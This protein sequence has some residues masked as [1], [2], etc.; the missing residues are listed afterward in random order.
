M[1][2]ITFILKRQPFEN[3]DLDQFRCILERSLYVGSTFI[4]KH[5]WSRKKKS[6]GR[7]SSEKK[8]NENFARG[9]SVDCRSHTWVRLHLGMDIL[10]SHNFRLLFLFQE[11][12]CNRKLKFEGSISRSNSYKGFSLTLRPLLSKIRM[13]ETQA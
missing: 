11:R 13:S 12:L 3:Y 2:Q 6:R 1:R 5:F 7:T 9:C 10:A 4:K 8:L